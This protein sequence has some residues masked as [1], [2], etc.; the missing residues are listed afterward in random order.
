MLLNS[1]FLVQ[2]YWLHIAVLGKTAA[3]L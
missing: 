2:L 1:L 3:I